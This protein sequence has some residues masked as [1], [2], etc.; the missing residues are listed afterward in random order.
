VQ[1]GH[2]MSRC[3]SVLFN[4]SQYRVEKDNSAVWSPDVKMC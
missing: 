1:C 3:V 4:K 2:L